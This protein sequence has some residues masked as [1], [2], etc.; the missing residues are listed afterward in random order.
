MSYLAVVVPKH[1]HFYAAGPW[2]AV[3]SF[4]H[5]HVLYGVQGISYYNSQ[6][7]LYTITL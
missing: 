3:D 7:S 6:L 2:T 5:E 4:V 1:E